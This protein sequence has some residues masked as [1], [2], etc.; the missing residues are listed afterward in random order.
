VWCSIY[1]PL[2]Q[3]HE[4]FVPFCLISWAIKF[5]L[6]KEGWKGDRLL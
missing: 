1:S 5:L 3:E 4:V 6:L 2:T